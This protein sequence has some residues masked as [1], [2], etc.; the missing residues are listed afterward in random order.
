MI[1]WFEF[2]VL[3]LTWRQNMSIMNHFQ[4]IGISA[5]DRVIPPGGEG[6]GNPPKFSCPPRIKFLKSLS[7]PQSVEKFLGGG[8]FP[9]SQG[10]PRGVDG[11]GIFHCL[12]GGGEDSEIWDHNDFYAC[13][14]ILT[15][16]Y[17]KP[18]SFMEN[19]LDLFS[20]LPNF[21]RRRNLAR[22]W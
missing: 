13:D 9:M 21:R 22:G 17:L 8:G 16:F 3:K 12:R 2:W 7:C 20:N 5:T 19:K 11:R 10:S 4:D 1:V 18:N 14:K 15:N 6:M